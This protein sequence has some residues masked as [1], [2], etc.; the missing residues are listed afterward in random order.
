MLQISLLSSKGPR[1][2]RR[3]LVA[4]VVLQCTRE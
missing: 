3:K 4:E 2:L 1:V